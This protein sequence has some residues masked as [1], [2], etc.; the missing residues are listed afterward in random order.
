MKK[1][2]AMTR[3]EIAALI[4]RAEARALKEGDAKIITAIIK[5]MVEIEGLYKEGKITSRRKLRRVMGIPRPKPSDE[6]R[7]DE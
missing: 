4:E 7:A 6:N 3:D 2:D 1:E 5:K